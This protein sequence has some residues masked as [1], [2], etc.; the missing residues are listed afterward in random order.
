MKVNCSKVTNENKHRNE[1]LTQ[2]ERAKRVVEEHKIS[3]DSNLK[4]FTVMETDR[5]HV[6]TLFPKESCSCPSTSTCYHILAAKLSIGETSDD[7]TKKKLN[8]TRLRKNAH[9]R[10]DKTSGRK[11]PRRGDYDVY[12]APD[13]M[14][15]KYL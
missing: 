12:P 8:L 9:S 2:N 13:A 15:G 10:S 3:L 4:T 6:V 7:V 5:P 11:I 1:Q 14:T